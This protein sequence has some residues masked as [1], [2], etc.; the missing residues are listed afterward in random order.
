[1]FTLFAGVPRA[2]AQTVAAG[3]YYATPSWDQTLACTASATCPRFI[4]LSN[5]NNEAY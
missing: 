4:V 2:V 3:P 5:F 1:M